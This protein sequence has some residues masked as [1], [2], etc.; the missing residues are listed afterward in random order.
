MTLNL[1]KLDRYTHLRGAGLEEL[2]WRGSDDDDGP[3]SSSDQGRQ[4]SSEEESE[5][6]NGLEEFTG[7]ED[8]DEEEKARKHATL[9]K[10]EQVRL[11]L[12]IR[13]LGCH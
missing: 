11:S 9:S 3:D 5:D 8:D 2:E 6:E 1:E 10:A 7:D 4:G 13:C 12:G